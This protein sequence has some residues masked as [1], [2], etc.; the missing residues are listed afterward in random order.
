MHRILRERLGDD[1]ARHFYASCSY[2]AD[3]V[4]RRAFVQIIAHQPL[5]YLD[6]AGMKLRQILTGATG[7]YS[8]EFD[9]GENVG[10]V[11]IGEPFRWGVRRYTQEMG[12]LLQLGATLF[13]PFA[14][15]MALR[16]GQ[17]AWALLL[18]PIAYQYG[19]LFAGQPGVAVHLERHPLQLAVLANG[20][21][22]LFAALARR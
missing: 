19:E 17:R 4:L 12:H 7:T 18:A 8:G 6:L 10:G 5:D 20:L 2:E 3:L 16:R 14:V 1:F 15:W 11:G 22:A 9:E 13:A 21:G